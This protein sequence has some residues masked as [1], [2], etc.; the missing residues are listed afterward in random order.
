MAV[1]FDYIASDFP[2]LR[3]L[4]R[5]GSIGASV[6]NPTGLPA[7]HAESVWATTHLGVLQNSCL[8]A[9][10][11]LIRFLFILLTV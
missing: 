8:T 4:D 3:C 2:G 11:N 9:N 6:R 7:G 5:D 10:R 1:R